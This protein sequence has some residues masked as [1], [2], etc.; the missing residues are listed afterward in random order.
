VTSPKRDFT[1]SRPQE[2][3]TTSKLLAPTFVQSK[4]A[5]HRESCAEQLVSPV[6]LTC[7]RQNSRSTELSPASGPCCQTGRISGGGCVLNE[8]PEVC[9]ERELLCV[10]VKRCRQKAAAVGA[11]LVATVQ[12]NIPEVACKGPAIKD[13]RQR[14]GR[15]TL[16]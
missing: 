3:S 5:E 6:I 7:P 8:R 10:L 14:T 16:R 2:S 12:I 4:P 11:L 9:F 15:R 1:N 13:V